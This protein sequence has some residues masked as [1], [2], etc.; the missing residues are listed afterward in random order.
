MAEPNTDL[1][2][3][4]G[5]YALF[6]D[7]TKGV[8]ST[9]AGPMN[10][11]RSGNETPVVWDAQGR[12]FVETDFRSVVRQYVTARRNEY[13]VL[14]NPA[15][16]DR[17]P[18]PSPGS[19]QAAADLRV[20]ED[21]VIPGPCT[22]ALW[23]GQSAEVIPGHAL[24]SNQFLIVEVVDEE[25]AKSNWAKAT[26]KKTATKAP[27]TQPQ[28]PAG[29]DGEVDPDA[30]LI[31]AQQPVSIASADVPDD[32]AVGQRYLI[33]GD[34]VRFY[35]PCTGVQ[36]V[37]DEE[38]TRYVRDALTLE[39]L[40]YAILIDENGN[41]TFP[42]GPSVVFPSPTQAFVEGT[43]KNSDG[44]EEAVK[45]YRPIELNEIQGLHLKALRAHNFMGRELTEGEEFFLTGKDCKL[46]YPHPLH[47]SVKYDGKAQHYATGIPEGDSRYLLDRKNGVIELVVGPKMLLPNPVDQVIVR[48]VLTPGE[49]E[50]WY[51]GNEEA[52]EYNRAL[53]A[54]LSQSPT[55]R[56]GVSEGQVERA[57]QTRGGGPL[58]AA[59][60]NMSVME[61]SRVSS[62]QQMVGEE[63]S[64]SSTFN[65]PRTVTF[66]D[67]YAGAPVIQ[68][69]PGYAAM[70]VG[71]DGSRKVV[72]S[73][74]R[75]YLEYHEGLQPF[76][77]STGRP[78]SAKNRR[79]DVYLR[80]SNNAVRDEVTVI[81]KDH[82]PVSV[83]VSLRIS[84]D[85]TTQ[86][87]M[88]K[89]WNVENY[90][91]FLCDH[92]RS[93]VQAAVRKLTLTE[94]Y[95]TPAECIRD[96]ILGAAPA[97][98][99]EGKAGTT[100]RP[101]LFFEENNLRVHDVDVLEIKIDEALVQKTIAETALKVVTSELTLAQK[102]TAVV[103]LE[104]QT[105]LDLR[106][107]ELKDEVAER[108]HEDQLENLARQAKVAEEQANYALADLRAREART[109]AELAIAKKRDEQTLLLDKA[110]HEEEE[111]HAK[112][113]A[114]TE[115]TAL[116]R[117][118]AAFSPKLADA[119]T[120]MSD[121][122]T[123]VDLAEAT[124]WHRVIGGKNVVESVK[125]M[126][127]EKV[128]GAVE[129][130]S[131]RFHIGRYMNGLSRDGG[132]EAK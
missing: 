41:K 8:V 16:N 2:L 116:E 99:E 33:K 4:N 25:A 78:K 14:H 68:P 102:E 23:P 32:L 81:T 17:Q 89:W 86:E 46:Y 119:L 19:K 18:H 34:E 96:I 35:M 75:H 52:A 127:G 112:A 69:W 76:S 31:E 122:R 130:L 100:K 120:A 9:V 60:A 106:E 66:N 38:T 27:V 56:P 132:A 39:I 20:G 64:R 42:R 70:V 79:R 84:F 101:G 53:R 5:V 40:E 47:A 110:S 62:H 67:K 77:F 131:E 73:G 26:F 105:A 87:E 114:E 44:T 59:T 61:T 123:M 94:F 45:S 92:I 37:K 95:A 6:R 113:V 49:C 1:I 121:K 10:I 98:P 57:M 91:K 83:Y 43:R 63:I 104:K 88:Q 85:G 3:T 126:L 103:A 82:V 36:V 11:S 107:L 28:L 80:V 22:F 12:M 115:T 54:Q 90:V 125:G 97:A 111:R 117:R 50:L 13:V 30:P 15:V 72:M 65:Q 128:G 55:T 58:R 124:A 7:N 24:R 21:V 118:F 74:E 48:R 93:R 29:K 108:R 51:P 109:E 71:K 129:K